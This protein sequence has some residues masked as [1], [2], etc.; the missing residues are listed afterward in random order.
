[1]RRLESAPRWMGA[2]AAT[3]GVLALASAPAF[4][5][6]ATG[7]YR[8]STAQRIGI[9][10]VASEHAVRGVTYAVKYHCSTGRSYYGK[11]LV[12]RGTYPIREGRFDARWTSATG[13]TVSEVHGRIRGRRARGTVSRTVR[14]DTVEQ[15][16][17]PQ[18]DELC[19][20]GVVRFRARSMS[21]HP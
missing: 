5:G 8:G 3:L 12:D 13:A 10:F 17:D 7:A 18:G 6:H 20:S 9:D 4:A 21:V 1:M 16:P 2:V 14:I 11:P 15:Q 19:E